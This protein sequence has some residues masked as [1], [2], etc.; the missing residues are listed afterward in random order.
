MEGRLVKKTQCSST[1]IATANLGNH[2]ISITK[3]TQQP[4][5]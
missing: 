2:I 5:Q 3:T 1:E 4:Y